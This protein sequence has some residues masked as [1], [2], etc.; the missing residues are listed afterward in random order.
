MELPA[1]EIE[2]WRAYYS[3]FPFPQERYDIGVA[4]IEAALYNVNRQKKTDKVWKVTDLLP[5]Y[6]KKP[7]TLKQQAEA[8]EAFAEKL[9]ALKAQTQ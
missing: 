8:D 5:Q 4:S 1:S 2:F 6:I 3:I 9:T 7:L